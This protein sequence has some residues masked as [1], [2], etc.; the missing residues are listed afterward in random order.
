MTGTL[1]VTYIGYDYFSP[2]L[3]DLVS[4]RDVTIHR[5]VG[6]DQPWGE[7]VRRIAAANGIPLATTRVTAAD[8]LRFARDSDLVLCASYDHRLLLPA[9][10]DCVFLNLHPSLLPLGRGP[11]PMHWALTTEPES[12]GLTLHVMDSGFDTGP[13]VAQTPLRDHLPCSFERYTHLA[14][15]AAVGLIRQIDLAGVRQLRATPQDEARATYRPIPPEAARTILPC[16]TTQSIV[17]LVQAM[18][19]LG[20][21]VTIG[22][23]GYRVMRAEAVVTD[24]PPSG[25]AYVNNFYGYYPCADGYC[26]FPRADLQASG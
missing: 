2:V 12:A 21:C 6:T 20:A 10:T 25:L 14:N 8:V 15:Q 5:V 13:I 19:E 1:R 7:H 4:R 9:G 11:A 17:A 16:Q 22:G 23:V 26:L 3:L 24:P 18:G